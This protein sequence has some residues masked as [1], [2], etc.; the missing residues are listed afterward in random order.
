MI[1]ADS[2]ATKYY[3]VSMDTW[4]DKVVSIRVMLLDRS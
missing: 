4:A 1:G 3:F 2:R